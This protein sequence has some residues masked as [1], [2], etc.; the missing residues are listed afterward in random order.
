MMRPSFIVDGQRHVLEEEEEFVDAVARTQEYYCGQD[1]I[2]PWGD[3]EEQC[4]RAEYCEYGERQ[5]NDDDKGT[6]DEIPVMPVDYYKRVD[7]FLSMPPPSFVRDMERDDKFAQKPAVKFP[8]LSKESHKTKQTG[9]TSVSG[10]QGHSGVML[11]VLS[12]N[13]NGK[14]NGIDGG[15]LKEAFEY[16]DRLLRDAVADELEE[17]KLQQQYAMSAAAPKKVVRSGS[18]SDVTG[19]TLG[20]G[21]AVYDTGVRK[22]APSKKKGQQRKPEKPTR[23]NSEACGLVSRLRQQAADSNGAL[24]AFDL[25]TKKEEDGRRCPLDFDALVQNF[26]QG[27]TL[28]RLKA[29]LEDSKQSMQRSNDFLRQMSKDIRMYR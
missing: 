13:R 12:P 9:K 1:L 22:K 27:L 21:A 23:S 11:G 14:K 15:L 26:E 17:Q 25:S 28:Q 10:N 6:P 19:G 2:Q 16:A 18:A 29:E 8:A 7:D 24:D 5:E 20:R 3:D 4:D